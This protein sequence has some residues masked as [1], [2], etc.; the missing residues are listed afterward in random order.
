MSNDKEKSVFEQKSYITMKSTIHAV[1]PL[2]ASDFDERMLSSI[3]AASDRKQSARSVFFIPDSCN[4]CLSAGP[5]KY[6]AIN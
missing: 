2:L 5:W 3:N 1:V 6:D 4:L